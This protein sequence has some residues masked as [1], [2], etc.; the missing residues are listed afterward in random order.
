MKPKKPETNAETV[1]S[2]DKCLETV[3]NELCHHANPLHVY[4]RLVD[5]GV[6]RDRA[7]ALAKRYERY[8]FK[9]VM[10]YLRPGMYPR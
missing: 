9:P 5:Y 7:M 6:A 8:A 3:I 2:K 10:R 1:Q 4:C